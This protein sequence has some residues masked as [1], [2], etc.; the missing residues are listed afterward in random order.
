MISMGSYAKT[1]FLLGFVEEIVRLSFVVSQEE[2]S[3]AVVRLNW[4]ILR[5]VKENVGRWGR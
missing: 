2:S 1:S 4:E 3:A 5:E